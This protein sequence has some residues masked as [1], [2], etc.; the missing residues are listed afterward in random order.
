MQGKI[1]RVDSRSAVVEA[2]SGIFHCAIRGY[3]KQGRRASRNLVAVGDDVM[4]DHSSENEGVIQ[5]VLPRRS[6]LT[7]PD[8]F[9]P[10]IEHVI[11][12]NLDMVGI[13]TSVD[14]PTYNGGFVDRMIASCQFHDLPY[15]IIANK[16]DYPI[17]PEVR[18][19]MDYFARFGIRH[20][21]TS[22]L[23]L[24]GLEELKVALAGKTAIFS[25]QS[26]VGKSSLI[27]ALYPPYFAKVTAVS[28]KTGKGKH[29]TTFVQLVR[30]DFDAFIA[31]TPGLKMFGI[32]SHPSEIGLYFPDFTPHIPQCRFNSCLHQTEPGCGV[33]AAV[34][35]GEIS[36]R[37]Y[38]SYL[39]I[40]ADVREMI[41]I[42]RPY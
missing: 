37:R 30:T 15:V 25:G 32:W 35:A 23:T 22:A 10:D 6:K 38:D 1:I 8:S 29:T 14:R 12:A 36:P 31:D 34:Q 27:T 26:G 9:R 41:R 18:Q 19:E 40:L 33:K 28:E 11:M 3:L 7:R 5:D 4:F 16:S 17:P 42:T 24:D 21:Y 2:E 20:I 39:K 13:V